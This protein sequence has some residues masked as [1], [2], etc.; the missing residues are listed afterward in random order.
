MNAYFFS[1]QTNQI[2][3]GVWGKVLSFHDS[4]E[5]YLNG[6]WGGLQKG[7]EPL[8]VETKG[9]FVLGIQACHQSADVND[10]P[11]TMELMIQLIEYG[12]FGID[13]GI[14]PFV[15]KRDDMLSFA[16]CLDWVEC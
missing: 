6:F 11:N 8:F 7:Q 2:V 12:F 16:F 9:A 14:S 15:H 10:V 4:S 13:R 3:I 5:D 1:D